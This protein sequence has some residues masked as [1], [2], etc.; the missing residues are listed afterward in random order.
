MTHPMIRSHSAWAH[1]HCLDCGRS[2]LDVAILQGG[3][4]VLVP[5]LGMTWTVTLA[6]V[7]NI[8]S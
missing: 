8:A 7:W 1:A 3:L 5:G 2:R 6:L 4:T